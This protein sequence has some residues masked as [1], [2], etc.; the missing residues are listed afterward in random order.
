MDIENICSALTWAS[1]GSLYIHVFIQNNY[2]YYISYVCIG[3][4]VFQI[5]EKVSAKKL[6][7]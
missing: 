1:V 5:L 7:K 4:Y 3:W 2:V 6:I